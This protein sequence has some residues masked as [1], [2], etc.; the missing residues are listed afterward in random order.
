MMA[1]IARRGFSDRVKIVVM[2]NSVWCRH[3]KT[4]TS[5]LIFRCTQL[6]KERFGI[7]QVDCVKAL[8]EPAIERRK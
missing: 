5:G 7:F 3:P 4:F 2:V 1:S 6:S 8:G